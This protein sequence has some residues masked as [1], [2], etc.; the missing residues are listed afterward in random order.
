MSYLIR[1]TG[2]GFENYIEKKLTAKGCPVERLPY[3]TPSADLIATITWKNSFGAN[4]TGTLEN[5]IY[6]Y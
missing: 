5:Y 1:L 3:G 4:N 2:I 6:N